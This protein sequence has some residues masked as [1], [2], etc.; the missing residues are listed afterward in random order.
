MTLLRNK[1]KL[2]SVKKIALEKD[3]KRTEVEL[4]EELENMAMKLIE[5]SLYSSP[6]Q[7][8]IIN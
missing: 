8:M 1:L 3:E 5:K 7:M 4:T 6:L 2:E